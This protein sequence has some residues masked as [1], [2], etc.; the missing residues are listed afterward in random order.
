MK[1]K[2][3]SVEAKRFMASIRAKKKGA[4]KAPAKKL[5]GTKKIPMNKNKPSGKHTD[6]KS[7]NYNITISGVKRKTLSRDAISEL[8]SIAK[9]ESIIW[10]RNS[11][12]TKELTNTDKIAQARALLIEVILSNGYTSTPAGK[13]IKTTH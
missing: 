11:W 5:S 4:K 13:L 1:L 8:K 3:G 6:I 10:K 12:A 7:H 2:K 9:A